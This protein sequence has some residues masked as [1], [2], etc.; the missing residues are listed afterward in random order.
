LGKDQEPIGASG[1]ARGRRGIGAAR[2]NSASRHKKRSLQ[3]LSSLKLRC[4]DEQAAYSNERQSLTDN[5]VVITLFNNCDYAT[6]YGSRHV[7]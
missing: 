2:E 5:Y 4:P 6:F 3:G 1:E 7:D